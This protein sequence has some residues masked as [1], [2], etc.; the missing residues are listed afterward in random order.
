MFWLMQALSRLG[1]FLDFILDTGEQAYLVTLLSPVGHQWQ[2]EVLATDESTAYF[3]VC[4][5]YPKHR[6][7]TVS[8]VL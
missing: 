3:M 8:L 1:D 7:L 6:V 2:V 4:E 5:E